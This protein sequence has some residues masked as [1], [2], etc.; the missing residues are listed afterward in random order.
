LDFEFKEHK[1]IRLP[2][3]ELTSV[4]AFDASVL[5]VGRVQLTISLSLAI[6]A[7]R[8][9]N[10]SKARGRENKNEKERSKPVR[11]LLDRNRHCTVLPR[12]SRRNASTL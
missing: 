5:L 8:L 9:V 2:G 1:S 3:A 6:T 10:P 11:S 4:P 7:Y 12:R